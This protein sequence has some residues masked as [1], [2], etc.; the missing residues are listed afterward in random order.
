[1]SAAS[2]TSTVDAARAQRSRVRLRLAMLVVAMG[3]GGWLRLADLQDSGPIL[4]DDAYMQLEARFFTTGARALRASAGRWIDE[5]RT[6]QDL[7]KLEPEIARIRAETIGQPPFYGRPAHTAATVALMGLVGDVPFVACLASALLGWLTIPL[8]GRLAE[9]LGARFG[10]GEI[11]A[12]ITTLALAFAPYHVLYSREGFSEGAS[13]FFVGVALN[14]YL[15]SRERL[16]TEP[17]RGVPLAGLS[18]GLMLLSHARWAI[19]GPLFLALEIEAW[20]TGTLPFD[21]FLARIGRFALFAAL[22]LAAAELPYYGVLLLNRRL[23]SPL[24]VHTYLEQNLYQFA[25]GSGG[26]LNPSNWPTY[27]YLLTQVN[28]WLWVGALVVG[29]LGCVRARGVARLLPLGLLA[30]PAALFS[31]SRVAHM[32][33]GVVLTFAGAIAIGVGIAALLHDRSTRVRRVALVLGVLACGEMLARAVELRSSRY[34]WPQAIAWMRAHGGVRHVST[35]AYVSE[36]YTSGEAARFIPDTE[37]EL[38]RL[39]RI[40]HRYLVADVAEAALRY[41]PKFAD[42]FRVYESAIRG[43]T[44]VAEFPNPSGRFLQPKFEMNFDFQGTLDFIRTAAERGDDR[45]RIY[46]LTTPRA[47]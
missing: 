23:A 9:R 27:P 42:R 40:G 36:V 20:R 46:D 45:I 7:W 18:L 11:A 5:R 37:A 10:A 19:L 43:R 44:P 24:P 12:P 29:L 41:N 31:V 21:R 34:A 33:Y 14:L 4:W 17:I 47:P 13:L 30:I 2:A 15:R 3:V 8:A 16:E 28:G 6:G 1:M 26:G 35:Q 22:P 39:V 25:L 32:R 38:D